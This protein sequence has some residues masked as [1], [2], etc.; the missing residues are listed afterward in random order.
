MAQ[1]LKQST[2][3]TFLAGPFMNATNGADY[4]TSLSIG[5]ANLKISKNGANFAQTSAASPATPYTSDGHY[6]CPLT[7]TDTNT[8]GTMR[9]TFALGNAVLPVW[10]DFEVVPANVFESLV[11]GTEFL[12]TT[13]SRPSFNVAAGVLTVKKTDGNTTQFTK[14]VAVDAAADPIIGAA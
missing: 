8:L 2:A 1:L 12:E 13:G 4:N 3:F 14:N 10:H 11:T 6:Q 5:Q 7:A 9:V